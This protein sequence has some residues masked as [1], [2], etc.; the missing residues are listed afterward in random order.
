M[1]TPYNLHDTALTD[2]VEDLLA[3]LDRDYPDPADLFEDELARR[4]GCV[5]HPSCLYEDWRRQRVRLI[6][7]AEPGEELCREVERWCEGD[8][9]RHTWPPT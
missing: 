7:A 3:A 8:L 4:L 2:A 9:G 6:E 5:R 1:R